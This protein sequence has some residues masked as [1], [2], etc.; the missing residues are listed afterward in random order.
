M[1]NRLYQATGEPW[2]RAAARDWFHRALRMRRT[3][4][5]IAGYCAFRQGG[6][7][8]DPGILEGA[9]G[10][11]LALAA[12]VTPVAPDWDRVMLLAIP[13]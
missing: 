3:G 2:L 9:A 11:A 7:V 6:F 8:T 5:G 13:A 10:I 12:A 4:R 1:F